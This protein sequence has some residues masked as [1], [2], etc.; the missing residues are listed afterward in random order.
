MST[1]I[2][3]VLLALG[4]LLLVVLLW[5]T[6]GRF[7]KLDRLSGRTTRHQERALQELLA[8]RGEV[9]ATRGDLKAT[10]AE[11][12]A[13][14]GELKALSQK[15]RGLRQDSADLKDKVVTQ[16]QRGK[17]FFAALRKLQH[18]IVHYETRSPFD[19][20]GAEDFG[21]VLP[22]P[23]R[24]VVS[25][26]T[27][28]SRLYE[29]A[30]TIESVLNQT[31]RPDL[32]VLWLDEV[33]SEHDVPLEVRAMQRRGLTVRFTRDIGPHTKLVP[34][35]REYPD[36]VVITVDDDVLYPCY[37]VEALYRG[38][39]ADPTKIYCTRA[40]RITGWG[41]QL[42]YSADWP[43]VTEAAEGLDIFPLGVGGVLY[44]PRVLPEAVFDE[45]LQHKL[46]PTADDV[47]FK[48]MSLTRRVVCKRVALRKT[49]FPDRPFSQET[50]LQI[51]NVQGRQNEGQIRACFEYFS[52]SSVLLSPESAQ[53]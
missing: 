14:R 20:K 27:T 32:V 28:A 4:W 12:K 15:V 26:T 19:E 47:W 29:I 49:E 23:Q 18:A 34:A 7:S 46:C 42:R 33:L 30:P 13:L 21:L 50:G 5:R 6:R 36:E 16:R 43:N 9:K 52:V 48:T 51:A 31:V 17:E 35:L 10:R 40:R 3:V 2:S 25:M 8:V 22:R 44:P 45:E 38:Y 39:L 11:V 53:A 1:L 24:I 41:E 37:L